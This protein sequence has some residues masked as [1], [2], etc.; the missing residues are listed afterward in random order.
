MLA[1]FEIA[2]KRAG[3]VHAIA[4]DGRGQGII[5]LRVARAQR[6][7]F[8]CGIERVF[9]QRGRDARDLFFAVHARAGG[10]QQLQRFVAEETHAGRFENFQRVFVNTFFFRVA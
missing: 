10:F 6:K 4:R 9:H 2:D 5:V 7:F 3:A 8:R 1:R